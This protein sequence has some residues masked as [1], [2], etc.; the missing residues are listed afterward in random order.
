MKILLTGSNGMVGRNII[1]Y[2][3]VG[4][5][6]F[7][8]PSS[9]ELDLLNYNLV[10]EYMQ[11]HRPDMVIHSAGLVGGIQ[12]NIAHPV[13]FLVKNLDMGRNVI[14]AA[15]ENRVLKFMNL[16]S[17]CMYPKEAQNPLS[18]NLILK[19]E[20]EPTN[21][22]YALAKIVAT[23]LCEYI[24]T[25]DETLMYKTI[26]PCN[27]YGR[28]DKFDPS[29]SH[30]VPAVIKKIHD[31]KLAKKDNIGIWGDGMARREF[32]YTGDLAA[33]VFYAIENFAK[34]P[35]TLNVGLGEDYTINDYYHIIAKEIGFEGEF[36]NDLS[37]PIGM[38]QKLVD[39]TKLKEFGWN[40][41]TSLSE[42]I[43]KTFEFYKTT[44]Q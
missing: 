1:E 42:G 28:F 38:K 32:M 6:D 15:R 22:G 36:V 34:M 25:E 12:A 3:N 11:N 41:K 7:L 43:R 2:S 27:L 40:H 21:E 16:S 26:V 5:Y 39:D 23:R 10:F 8:T 24:C 19:G 14:I 13:D 4:Q 37:K 35:Q 18:E 33:F 30:M 29:H 20:L 31:A 17:S 44:L 9:T